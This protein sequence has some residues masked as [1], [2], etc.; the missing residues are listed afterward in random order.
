[1]NASPRRSVFL[2]LAALAV[3]VPDAATAQAPPLSDLSFMTGCW[4][5]GTLEEHYTTP[6]AN[7]M[8]GVSRYLRAGVT[9]DYEFSRI[10]RSDSAVVL[11]PHPKGTASVG[12]RLT[13]LADQTATFENPAHDFPQRI[14]YRRD[15]ALLVARIESMAGEG[16]EWRMSAR[17]CGG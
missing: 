13:S 3:L 4:G 12:F 10:E 17:A 14:I 11:T 6:S 7:I 15:G 16:Q 5:D 1:M 8:L 9:R 2:A